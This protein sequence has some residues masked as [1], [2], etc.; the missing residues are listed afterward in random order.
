MTA[1]RTSAQ[2]RLLK[3]LRLANTDNRALRIVEAA[4]D[5][6][7]AKHQRAVVHQPDAERALCELV[8]GVC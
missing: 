8:D 6:R 1:T 5:V 7:N 4:I 2:E 3:D